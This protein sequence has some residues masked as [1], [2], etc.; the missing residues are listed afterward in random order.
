MP[1]GH[2]RTSGLRGA[3]NLLWKRHLPWEG[4]LSDNLYR[5]EVEKLCARHYTASQPRH[6]GAG[7]GH[8]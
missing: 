1:N 6:R 4:K 7:I 2:S 3:L 5:T 8:I